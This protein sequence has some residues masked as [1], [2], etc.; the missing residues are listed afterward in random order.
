MV[1]FNDAPGI[2]LIVGFVFLLMATLAFVSEEFRDGVGAFSENTV[3]EETGFYLNGTTYTVDD[4]S[5]CNFENFAVVSVV[6][7]SDT[8]QTVASG[9]YTTDA[10]AGTIVNATSD[11]PATT[12]VYVSYTY[13]YGGTTCNV[14]EDFDEE[15]DDNTSIAGMV[16][17]IALIGIV[18]SLLIAVFMGMRRNRM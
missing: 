4:A 14:T 8:S 12:E 9:N 15:L 1:S 7:S 11:W 3:S 6:N 5:R 16:L 13:D 17:T 2:V 10:D 18:L